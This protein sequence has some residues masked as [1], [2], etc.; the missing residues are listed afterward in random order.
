MNEK[1]IMFELKTES[2][3]DSAHF[4]TDY[5]GKCENLHGHRWRVVGYIAQEHLQSEGTHKDMVLDFCLFKKIFREEVARFD[6]TFLVEE[7]SLHDDTLECLKREG[8]KLTILP[9]RT[10]AENLAQYF[11]RA[12]QQKNLPVSCIEVYETPNNCAIYRPKQG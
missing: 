5:Y 10:T 12:L 6:H 7:G 8:F 1:R 11:Y 2:A 9:F 4:L 3:F